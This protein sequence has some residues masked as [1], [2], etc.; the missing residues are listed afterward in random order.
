MH[1]YVDKVSKFTHAR[2]KCGVGSSVE[3]HLQNYWSLNGTKPGS[4]Q[5]E[6]EKDDKN[7]KK[8]TNT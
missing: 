3:P 6:K 8:F 7:K 5:F 2:L 4:E 1:F